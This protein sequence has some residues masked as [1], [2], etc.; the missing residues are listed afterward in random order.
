M[1][2]LSRAARTFCDLCILTLGIMSLL[3]T[4]PSLA[5]GL[6]YFL[7]YVWAILLIVAGTV[8]IG[9]WLR[10][11]PIVEIVGCIAAGVAFAT[12]MVAAI[13]QPEVTSASVQVALLL[14]VAIALEVVRAVEV[15]RS[16]RWVVAP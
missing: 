4:P 5:A 6:S 12:W 13:T 11:C 9:G 8:C 15:G 2:T 1:N 16:A 7:T 3:S 10:D 14:L